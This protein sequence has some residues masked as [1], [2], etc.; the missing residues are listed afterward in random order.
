MALDVAGER[1]CGAQ[2]FVTLEPCNH[3]GRTP[4]CAGRLIT[5]GIADVTIGMPDPNPDVTGG[6]AA[7]LEAAGVTVRWADDPSP[8]ER[9]NEAWLARMRTGRPFVTAKI[10]LTLDGRP[11]VATGTRT[12]ITGI[13][14]AR[15]TMALRAGATAVAVGRATAVIDDP[16]LIVRHP[17]GTV[18]DGHQPRRILLCRD[19]LPPPGLKMMV[20]GLPA[21]MV[22]A[23]DLA[24]SSGIAELEERGIPVLRYAAVSGLVGALRALAHEGI[25]DLLVETGPGLLSAL[26][27][28][29][30]IDELVTFTAGGMG[31]DQAPCAFSGPADVSDGG[32]AAR[33]VP[34]WSS[35]QG[36]D[37]LAAWRPKILNSPDC[38]EGSVA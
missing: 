12:R 25:D 6:G 15:V 30:L 13:G 33:F 3:Y 34:V 20:D 14:A 35:I 9:Q 36:E 23:S 28:A 5:A 2:A 32:L 29:A 8:F 38:D 22:L 10:A 21:P 18:A 37:L 16:A 4:P 11:T 24:P 17:D 1:A 19:S 31:G 27:S 7:A 26:W